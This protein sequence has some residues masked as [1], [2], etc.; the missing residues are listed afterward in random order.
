MSSVALAVVAMLFTAGSSSGDFWPTETCRNCHPGIVAQHLDSPH[1][2]SFTNPAFQ[3]Q[4]FKDL[5]PRLGTDRLLADEARRCTA[6]HDPT[7]SEKGKEYVTRADR[8]GSA[9]SG[10]T[11]DVCHVITGFTGGNPGNGNFVVEPGSMKYGPLD[12]ESNWHHTHSDFHGRSEFCGTCHD[13]VNHHGVEIKST[14]TEWKR[15]AFAAEGIQCQDCHMTADGFLTGGKPRF[16]SGKVAQTNM[17]SARE[18]ERLYTHRFPGAHSR[19]QV[20]GAVGLAIAAPPATAP[21]ATVNLAV[22]VDNRRTGHS[23][24]SGSTELRVVWLEV[25]ARLGAQVIAIPAVSRW[26]PSYVAGSY[27][28]AGLGELDQR[29]LGSD[30]PKGSRAYRAVFADASG[31]PTLA[32]YDAASVICDT[33]LTAGEKRTERYSFV[34]PAKATGTMTIRATLKY[35]AYPT[36]FTRQLGLPKAETVEIAD[37]AVDVPI[38]AAPAVI[39]AE[40]PSSAMPPGAAAPDPRG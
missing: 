16:E 13:A 28:I 29:L 9:M 25:T 35:L 18:R 40:P 37:V 14:Y 21:A 5:L 26:S 15:S 27:E 2:R 3:A 36:A 23:L 39:R 4:Y 32:S 11:C 20:A 33:R 17:F 10:V 12:Q 6:C 30:V 38:R 34:V 22:E 31:N 7:A 1:E 8:P 24:P 19:T